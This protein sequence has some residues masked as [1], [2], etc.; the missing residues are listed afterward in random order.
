MLERS[1]RALELALEAARG[2]NPASVSD[3]GVAAA[4]ALAAAEGASLNGTFLEANIDMTGLKP[5]GTVRYTGTQVV[6]AAFVPGTVL[7]VY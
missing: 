4:V 2:G 6:L 7:K 1:V 3:A 5:K